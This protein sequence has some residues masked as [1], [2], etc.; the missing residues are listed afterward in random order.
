MFVLNQ[1]DQNRLQA[2]SVIWLATV[3][4]NGAP[5]LV[6]IWYLW[7]Q[8]K[9]YICTARDSVK[10]RNVAANRRVVLALEDG[11]DPLVIEGD[12]RILNEIPAKVSAGFKQKYDWA[13][14]DDDTYDVVIEIR[15]RRVVL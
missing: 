8:D 14:D 1:P 11:S 12:A 2:A 9:L 7:V 6:P 3:R 5:H 15:L 4:S 13:I 10:A